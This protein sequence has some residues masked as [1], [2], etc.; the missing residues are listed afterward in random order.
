[1][2]VAGANVTKTY[3]DTTGTLTIS[4]SG[5]GG[6]GLPIATLT[7]SGDATGATDLAAI[8]TAL[9]AGSV[10]LVGNFV[11][12]GTIVIPSDRTLILWEAEVRLAPFANCPLIRNSN[13]DATGNRNIHV[14]GIGRANL[15]GVTGAVIATAASVGATSL[16]L[17]EYL[18]PGTYRAGSLTSNET[19]QITACTATAPYTATL[20]APLA[21][22]RAV[23]VGVF[24]QLRPGDIRLGFGIY[25]V[26]VDGYSVQ[27]IGLGPTAAFAGIQ[28]LCKN[29]L[30]RGVRLNQND[31]T[32]NQDGIDVGSGCRDIVIDGIT[33]HTGDDLCSIYAQN[34]SDSLH[35]YVKTVSVAERDI[36]GVH[37]SNCRVSV[38]INPVRLQAG[39]GSKLSKVRVTNVTNLSTGGGWPVLQFGPGGYVTGLPAPADLS[40]IV[41]D[42]YTGPAKNV[43]DAATPFTDLTVRNVKIH[44]DW[45]RILGYTS[46]NGGVANFSNV[47]IENVSTSNTTGGGA[48][49]GFSTAA[50]TLSNVTF[51]NIL[52]RRG[53]AFLANSVTVTGVALDNVKAIVMGG[54]P[55]QSTVAE[56][57]QASNVHVDTYSAGLQRYTGAAFGL[58]ASGD[59]P[60]VIAGDA[61]PYAARGSLLRAKAG[62]DL[63]GGASA[64]GGLYYGDGTAWNRII[65][66]ANDGGSPPAV[67]DTTAPTVP[68]TPV[69]TAGATSATATTTGSTDAVGVTAYK[70][71]RNGTT[72]VTGQTTTSLTDTGLTAGTPVYYTVSALD[73]AGNESAQSANSNTVTPT[74]TADTTAPTVPGTP[75]ATAGVTSASVAFT[76][77]T[78][79]T[80]VTGYRVYSSAD[81]YTAIAATGATSPINVT[82]LAA[83][84]AVTFKVSAYDAAG[85]AS[86]QSA[87][88]NSVTPTAGGAA[89]LT[90]TF[91]DTAG[92]DL[93]T[94]TAD[95]GATWSKASG[96]TGSFVFTAANKVRTPAAASAV[97]LASVTPPSADYKVEADLTPVTITAS[98][99][100]GVAL[101]LS[102]SGSGYCVRYIGAS[103]AWRLDRLSSGS[104]TALATVPVTLVAGQTYRVR[105]TASGS[106]I[107]AH[108][109]GVQI[110]SV[111]DGTH[112]A[113]GLAGMLG[114]GAATDTVGWHVDNLEAV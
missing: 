94:H 110:A 105:V 29:G 88:S 16:V 21:S 102:G 35:S 3:N 63:T 113:A 56:T 11:T 109:D 83:G 20:A 86:A 71:R 33:G 67:S 99:N 10:I 41:L 66:L 13:Q 92:A 5:G 15:V 84:T 108:V 78:D 68:G 82:G 61:L 57:G 70:W 69:A 55:F 14:R 2:V 87:A 30:W 7:P 65:S 49:M 96:A 38:G 1:M 28:Q 44:G 74:A 36:I 37:L 52:L 85:N 89:F 48:M 90:D 100:V 58:I 39:D 40:D 97:Y 75:T 80:A 27:N 12:N 72:V 79:D 22:A 112:T 6:S 107:T 26:N 73:A 9:V 64:Q 51:R 4:S 18:R 81:G 45:S 34:S 91:T 106:T 19:V 60:E 76:G 77:S 8:N 59:M 98:H 32:V 62:V 23:G 17:K 101:R 50:A 104:G 93:T 53:T 111:T 95:S 25:L 114:N 46:A 43:V 42:G 54:V 31:S 24:N 103:A 47:V